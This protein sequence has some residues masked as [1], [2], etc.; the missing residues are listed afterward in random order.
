MV[1]APD[2]YGGVRG[3]DYNS[4]RHRLHIT[5]RERNDRERSLVERLLDMEKRTLYRRRQ[6]IAQRMGI[7]ATD[8]RMKVSEY[9]S[10]PD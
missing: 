5:E 8:I 6:L 2:Y 7:S 9:L 1:L 10:L 4:L 3:V